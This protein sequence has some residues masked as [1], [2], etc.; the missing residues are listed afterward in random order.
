MIPSLGIVYDLY[1][2]LRKSEMLYIYFLSVTHE[3]TCIILCMHTYACVHVCMNVHM[4]VCMSCMCDCT[5]HTRFTFVTPSTPSRAFVTAATATV[6]RMELPGEE[7]STNST[8]HLFSSPILLPHCSTRTPSHTSRMSA[9]ISPK[10][11]S[12]VIEQ[13]IESIK[14]RSDACPDTKGLPGT[15]T[16]RWRTLVVLGTCGDEGLATARKKRTAS[17]AVG[18]LSGDGSNRR[19]RKS[20]TC[21]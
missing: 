7:A 14:V 12:R 17:S 9:V 10:F 20:L 2:S 1:V 19:S 18:R 21:G 11:P 13:S 4:Y 6:P 5:S 15:P 8:T 16:N 3:C